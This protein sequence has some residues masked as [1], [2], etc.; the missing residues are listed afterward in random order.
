MSKRPQTSK[1]HYYARQRIPDRNDEYDSL[2]TPKKFH[3]TSQS[4]F[5]TTELQIRKTLA[6]SRLFTERQKLRRRLSRLRDE[7][8]AAEQATE[9]CREEPRSESEP[10][11]TSEK[12]V[13]KNKVDGVK[14]C[15]LPNDK[16]DNP[17]KPTKQGI[18][19]I[20]GA[21]KSGICN[22]WTR[23]IVEKV[24]YDDSVLLKLAE[25]ASKNKP[26]IP[27]P[28]RQTVNVD[29]ITPV[30][31]R[32]EAMHMAD[33]RWTLLDRSMPVSQSRPY[34]HWVMWACNRARAKYVKER[35]RLRMMKR[36][37]S[38]VR[39]Y[40]L[41]LEWMP[42]IFGCSVPPA[43]TLPLPN[44]NAPSWYNAPFSPSFTRQWHSR[45][46]GPKGKRPKGK[47]HLMNSAMAKV[48]CHKR[49]FSNTSYS[50]HGALLS[51]SASWR[52]AYS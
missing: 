39:R 18:Q 51:I 23:K 25:L 36:R 16:K 37:S 6:Q 45:M 38:M 15:E 34:E 24:K 1:A 8:Q 35:D 17:I 52:M 49:R 44:L 4:C 21:F 7:R 5:S 47:Q 19:G 42:K 13:E 40:L 31:I 27:S 14:Q 20:W 50:M 43:A 46:V 3:S 41:D 2:L 28:L 30:C 9:S 32:I 10:D 12:E 26:R 22:I 29:D 48:G 11:T 33:R